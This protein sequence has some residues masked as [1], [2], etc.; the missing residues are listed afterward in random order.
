[1][2]ILTGIGKNPIKN[3][4]DYRL[5]QKIIEDINLPRK[6]QKH[7]FQKKYEKNNRKRAGKP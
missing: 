3:N 1:M 5:V 7:T 6:Q 2:K 4:I